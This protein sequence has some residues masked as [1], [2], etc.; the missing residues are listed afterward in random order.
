VHGCNK[1]NP[2]WQLA[3][4]LNIPLDTSEG[5]YSEGWGRGAPWLASGGKRIGI[6]KIHR[7]YALYKDITT[8]VDRIA[9]REAEGAA[10]N[11]VRS[12]SMG[13]NDNLGSAVKEAREVLEQKF[14]KAH[15]IF[16]G[17][18]TMQILE[19][20]N[21]LWA[22]YCSSL[23]RSSLAMTV[24]ENWDMPEDRVATTETT[25]QHRPGSMDNQ[26]HTDAQL[27]EE[28]EDTQRRRSSRR[29]KLPS[30]AVEE[31]ERDESD[32]LVV[33]GYGPFLIVRYLPSIPVPAL[34]LAYVQPM[35][36]LVWTA[37]SLDSR[38]RRDL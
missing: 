9:A 29:S 33:G 5:G 18:E 31:N 22:G 35:S 12:K 14:S 3:R 30:V 19:S 37:G 26:I 11:G 27:A 21:V 32:G 6:D 20:I 7:I 4:D 24:D 36:R 15:S 10:S 13:L 23:D 1:F 34:A 17:E 2:V 8:E 25:V 28:L 16:Q 38:Y